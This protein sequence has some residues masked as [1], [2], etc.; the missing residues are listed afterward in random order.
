MDKLQH[1]RMIRCVFYDLFCWPRSP[2]VHQI[3]ITKFFQHIRIKWLT[4]L[5]LPRDQFF[6]S[7]KFHCK[8]IAFAI[9]NEFACVLFCEQFLKSID[10]SALDILF[11]VFAESMLILAGRCIANFVIHCW[12]IFV[13]RYQIGATLPTFYSSSSSSIRKPIKFQTLMTFF[14]VAVVVVL[15]LCWQFIRGLQIPCI[16]PLS[17]TQL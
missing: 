16:A 5:V 9:C 14:A 1:Y 6:K 4:R 11:N 2:L 8:W 3:I 15:L 12:K 13:G 17:S 10:V 7:N